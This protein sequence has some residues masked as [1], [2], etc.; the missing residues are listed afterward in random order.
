MKA[1][2]SVSRM[3][4]GKSAFGGSFLS[5]PLALSP[6]DISAPHRAIFGGGGRTLARQQEDNQRRLRGSQ[7]HTNCT[8]CV[9]TE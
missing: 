7:L 8:V 5:S 1:A 9:L 3:A 2:S 4:I 6:R